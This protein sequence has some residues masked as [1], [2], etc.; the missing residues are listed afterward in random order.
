[1]AIKNTLLGGTDWTTSSQLNAAD[2]NDTMDAAANYIKTLSTF[3]LNSFL[4]S[5]YDD[6]ESYSVGAFTTNSLWDVSSSGSGT[7]TTEIVSGT[8]AGGSGKE[9]QSTSASTSGG[10]SGYTLVKAIALSANKHTFIRLYCS[11]SSS[12]AANAHTSSVQISFD[13]GST[14]HD[15]ANSST[16]DDY[17]FFAL[18]Q[19]M[20][21]ATG[22]NNYDCYIGGKRVQQVSDATFQIWFRADRS[23]SQSGTQ[24][25]FAIDDVRQGAYSI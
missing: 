23:N 12:G 18:S 22:S 9:L 6:F 15:A 10:Q 4:Y 3:Y 5:V 25:R 16:P 20:T 19:I 24:A 7:F 14:Y 17:S 21:V 11:L 2:L 8:S 1:M 13:R